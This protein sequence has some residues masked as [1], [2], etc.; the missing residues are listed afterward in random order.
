MALGDKTILIVNTLDERPFLDSESRCLMRYQHGNVNVKD[1][2]FTCGLVLRVVKGKSRYNI[3]NQLVDNSMKNKV[4]NF[5]LETAQYHENFHIRLKQLF[6][7]K[8]KKYEADA[9]IS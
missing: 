1:S 2:A 5:D 3:E 7:E 4:V 8:F 6:V 9:I